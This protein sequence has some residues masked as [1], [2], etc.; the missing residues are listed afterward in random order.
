M[1]RLILLLTLSACS[2]RASLGTAECRETIH[3]VDGWG[4]DSVVCSHKQH[5]I[6]IEIVDNVPFAI[7]SCTIH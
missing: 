3:R 5:R 4:Y 2:P 1:T 7:C 6:R